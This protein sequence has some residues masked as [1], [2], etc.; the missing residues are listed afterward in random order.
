M[1]HGSTAAIASAILGALACATSAAQDSKVQNATDATELNEIVVTATKRATKLQDTP[2]AI[3]IVTG[4]DVRAKHITGLADVAKYALSF[5]VGDNS[6]VPSAVILT[7]RGLQS[8]TLIP[9]GDPSAAPHIDGIYT[10]RGSPRAGIF[11][12]ERIEVL[13]GAQGTL[14]G[15]N[16]TSGAINVVTAKPEFENKGYVS[17]GVGTKGFREILGAISIPAGDEFAVRLAAFKRE[18]DGYQKNLNPGQPDMADDDSLGGRLSARW[19]PGENLTLNASIDYVKVKG[20]GANYQV[21][22][23]AGLVQA[24]QNANTN[25]PHK[26]DYKGGGERLEVVYSFAN[27]DLVGLFGHRHAEDFSQADIDGAPVTFNRAQFRNDQRSYFAEMRAQTSGARDFSWT[28]GANYYDDK[29]FT[30]RPFTVD[31]PGPPELEIRAIY[32]GNTVKSYAF[33]ANTDVKVGEAWTLNGGVRYTNDNKNFPGA[34]VET[35]LVLPIGRQTPAVRSVVNNP[36][37]SKVTWTAGV[38]YKTSTNMLAYA[39]VATGYKAGGSEQGITYQP[40][41]VTGYEAGLK[42]SLFDR[43]LTLNLAAFYNDYKDLQVAKTVNALTLVENAATATTQGIEIEAALAT[44]NGFKIN[45]GVSF[46]KA[47]YGSYLDATDP[48]NPLTPAQRATGLRGPDLSGNYLPAAPT[49]DFI[50]SVEKEFVLGERTLTPRIDL[51]NSS[52]YWGT[53]FNNFGAYGVLG[54]KPYT[55][56]DA[57]LAFASGKGWSARLWGQN[58]TDEDIQTFSAIGGNGNLIGSYSDPRTYGISVSFDF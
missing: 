50:A 35:T 24:A 8:N 28:V 30:D 54:Q 32:P 27:V 57:S 31:I 58:L 45:A 42:T 21:L 15:R 14:F 10:S 20:A 12:V 4:E 39:K 38:N 1:K 40:E 26:L 5:Q 51:H 49:V 11:D 56:L 52:R 22:Q 13:R 37:F 34:R 29:L 17:A 44:A 43:M 7:I 33:F 2:I 36:K 53:E 16:S 9:S 47:K 41:T 23:P 46:L 18:H 55:R 19:E 3:G 25:T 48:R 6:V